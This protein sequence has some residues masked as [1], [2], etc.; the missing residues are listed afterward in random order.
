MKN[1]LAQNKYAL[2][3]VLD[4]P[5][6]DNN[7]DL[8]PEQLRKISMT[9]LN[10]FGIGPNASYL[11]DFSQNRFIEMD[12][13]IENITGI[14]AEEFIIKSPFET[15]SEIAEPA[16]MESIGALLAKS[17]EILHSDSFAHS[18]IICNLEH[19][20]TTRTGEKKRIIVQFFKIDEFEPDGKK[21]HKGRIV[22]ITHIRQD[23]LPKFFLM[24]DNEIFLTEFAEAA[25][26]IKN[27][28]IP[29][30]KTEIKIIQMIS[31]G[32]LA[33]EISHQMNI[34][35]STLYTHRKHIKSKMG[36]DIN[37]IIHLLKEKGIIYVV[38]L[39]KSFGIMTEQI[40]AVL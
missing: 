8:K 40:G 37:R 12:S 28:E 27:S 35:I 16:H 32:L 15:I 9:T 18:N 23:G 14:S 20:I 38:G 36:Q 3:N 25:S 19:N 13:S 1:R 4:F 17:R 6:D 33:K 7:P 29:L 26:I 11:F 24:K 21:L 39:T 10:C 2:K 22:D 34:S 5:V 30:S 31:E